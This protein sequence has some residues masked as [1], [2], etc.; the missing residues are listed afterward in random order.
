MPPVFTRVIDTLPNYRHNHL[1]IMAE[2]NIKAKE[3]ENEPQT[4]KL[5]FKSMFQKLHLE[6]TSFLISVQ[7]QQEELHEDP[8]AH[9]LWHQAPSHL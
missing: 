1:I 4:H 5:K 2:L 7:Y 3:S 6:L 8:R 9:C